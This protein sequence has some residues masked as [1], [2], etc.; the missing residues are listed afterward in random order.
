M[1]DI[2]LL[3]ELE[4][5][6]CANC[7]D[8]IE[9][10][11]K[12]LPDI[13]VGEV[14]FM[15]QSLRVVVGRH[16][17]QN[18]VASEIES[19]VHAIEPDVK[20]RQLPD[21]ARSFK[22]TG[23]ERKCEDRDGC[24]CGSVY[25]PDSLLAD[26]QKKDT[27]IRNL[28][29]RLLVGAVIFS[30]AFV[31][32]HGGDF[33]KG[34]LFSLYLT[35]YLIL[36]FPVLLKAVSNIGRGKVFDEHFLMAIATIG[37]LLISQWSEAAAVMLFYQLGELFQTTAVHRSRRSITEL[38]SIR[39]DYA[40]VQKGDALVKVSPD[41]VS[42]G[43]L[44][45]VK[46][47]E[48]VPLDGIVRTGRSMVDT[49]ALTGESVFAEVEQ[50]DTILSG[51]INK[52]GVL[53]VEVTASFGE[54]TVTKI[55]EM[56]TNAGS[57]KTQSE[58][59]ITRFAGIYTPVVVAAAILLAVIPPLFFG[60]DFAVWIY[61]A[62]SF[63]VISCPCALVISVPLGYFGGIG[64]AS[65]RGILVKGSNFLDSLARADSI[66]FDKTGTL[67][68]GEFAVSQMTPAPGFQEL[69]LLGA[70]SV[71]EWYSDH[72]IAVS[73]RR[74]AQERGIISSVPDTEAYVEMAGR[75]V[76]VHTDERDILVGNR[77]LMIESGV[78]EVPDVQTDGTLLFVAIDNRF[79]GYLE[80]A[81]EVKPEASKAIAQLKELHISRIALLTGDHAAAAGNVAGQLGITDV[82]SGML[83]AQKLEKV[84]ELLAQRFSAAAQKGSLVFVGDG[85]ND[86]PVLARADIGI[87]IGAL[88]SGA[89]IEAADIVIMT[90]D[91]QALPKAIRIARK[92]KRIVMENIFFALFVKGLILVLAA[93]GLI[94]LWFAI[95]ADVGVAIMAILNSIRAGR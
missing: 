20:V 82:Y 86:A 79:A 17:R 4:G 7:A 23:S 60:G 92:T 59:L 76:S 53:T 70:A 16:S 22:E 21:P 15:H 28:K 80:I 27:Q 61:R 58:N 69:D 12:A 11:V 32:E 94:G 52:D 42:I 26:S 3:F 29:T 88:A 54:S 43:D 67:T 46:P 63:L 78:I 19:I 9:K 66:I 81:D 18:S 5:L 64:A 35:A 55:I 1:Q 25:A 24:D 33:S 83:P 89:A 74:A 39:P 47:G 40:N 73:V 72:P 87:A 75:G 51:C 45:V 91:L 48:K 44:V 10:Q 57:R 77:K 37:A 50:G 14:N 68:K 38:L 30:A 2:E 65:K 36:G 84:E 95:F 13:S 62:L 6:G 41:C 49:S 90:D 56:V 34:I 85:I 31:L 71:A 8:K 93:L